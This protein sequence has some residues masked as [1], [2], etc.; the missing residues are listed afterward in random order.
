MLE[1][2]RDLHC[3]VV[4]D[5]CDVIP[6]LQAAF[7]R[8]LLP[9]TGRLAMVHLDAHP[10]LAVPAAASMAA[11][12]DVDKLYDVLCEEG[13]ISEFILPLFANGLLGQVTWVRSPWCGE[14]YPNQGWGSQEYSA[15]KM[16]DVSQRT[17][18]RTATHG[19]LG[20]TQ[21]SSYYLDD[22]A[23]YAEVPSITPTYHM[24]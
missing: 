3:A 7:R 15:F 8:K 5:H 6:F 19:A 14:P 23:V 20:V 10:D 13:G 9:V 12:E 17:Q 16:G 24:P 18:E 21:R 4:D 2:T 11:L 22:G 1:R